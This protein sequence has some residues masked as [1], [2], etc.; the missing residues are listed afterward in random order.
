LTL[1]ELELALQPEETG[2]L[3]LA[4]DVLEQRGD[5]TEA[6][7]FLR[8]AVML[9]PGA[10]SLHRQ[11]SGVL[12]RRGLLG[13]ARTELQAAVALGSNDPGTLAS[14]GR[15]F[16]QDKAFAEAEACFRQAIEACPDRAGF[17][18]ELATTLRVQGRLEEAVRHAKV[19]L[20]PDTT[21]AHLH[22]A[23]GHLLALQG[24]HLGAREYYERSAQL[25]PSTPAFQIA[26]QDALSREK[27]A[28]DRPAELVGGS[29]SRRKIG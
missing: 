27:Q 5:F 9:E 15:L 4:A 14:L 6:E 11:L 20:K 28:L 24:D 12:A 18:H 8:R 10:A 2:L 16:T 1:V 21:N 13:E 22:F 26:L 29:T 3:A 7:T 25:E 17:H 19:A 23:V